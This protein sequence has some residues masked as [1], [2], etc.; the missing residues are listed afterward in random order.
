MKKYPVIDTHYHL[1]ISCEACNPESQ[2]LQWME[3]G[4]VDVQI[5]MQLNEGT[6][7]HSPEWN[8]TLGNDFIA[9]MQNKHPGRVMGI[10]TVLPWYQ[11]PKYYLSGPKK[12]QPF[13]LVVGNPVTE[14]VERCIVDLGLWGFKIHPLEHCF[15]IDNPYIMYPMFEKATEVQKKVGR[16]LIMFIHAAG[17]FIGNTPEAIGEAARSFPELTFIVAHSGYAQATCTT[18]SVLGPLKNVWLDLTTM[19]APRMLEDALKVM[20]PERF[21]T[22]ADG[23]FAS[24]AMKNAIVDSFS[25]DEEVRALVQGGNLMRHFGLKWDGEKIIL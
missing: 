12:G 22:G 7:H 19:A 23:P 13:D 18:A 14:E 8:P 25:E 11:P 6:M 17:D 10:G 20:G 16:N 15:M 4:G 21:C 3:D 2:L 24:N 9:R 1:G 5:I